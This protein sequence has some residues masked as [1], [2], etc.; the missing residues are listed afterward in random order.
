[1]VVERNRDKG[2]SFCFKVM[3]YAL[4]YAHTLIDH[5]YLKNHSKCG[6]NYFCQCKKALLEARGVDR[7]F[8]KTPMR[9]PLKLDGKFVSP[10]NRDEETGSS[11]IADINSNIS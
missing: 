11:W 4:Y 3:G 8:L 9:G 10:S 5:C 1:M 7:P 6:H 2:S